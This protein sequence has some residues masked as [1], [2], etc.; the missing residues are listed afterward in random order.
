MIR[1]ATI[2]ALLVSVSMAFSPSVLKGNDLASG[3]IKDQIVGSWTVVSI[4]THIGTRTLSSPTTSHVKDVEPYGSN[5]KGVLI[6][7]P[8]GR[9]ASTLVTS[10]VSK[11]V[12]EDSNLAE[13]ERSF[14]TY[15][16]HPSRSM[17]ILTFE[18]SGSPKERYVEIT[19]VTA[20]ELKF[21]TVPPPGGGTYSSL[22]Y[23]RAE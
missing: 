19:S 10:E 11:S 5:P 1:P 4:T 3:A 22:V 14:G 21:V 13:L 16:I 9:F 7:Q 15:S 6:F 2:V 12:S 23:R 8:S 18:A 17:V 20:S